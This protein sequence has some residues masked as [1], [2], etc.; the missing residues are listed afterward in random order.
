MGN[1]PWAAVCL[2]LLGPLTVKAMVNK[3][4]WMKVWPLL[5]VCQVSSAVHLEVMHDYSTVTFLLQWRRF[6]AVC[7]V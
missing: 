7:G 3:K 5:L 6:I 4:S 1:L 2:D